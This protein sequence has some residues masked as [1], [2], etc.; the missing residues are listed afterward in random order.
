MSTRGWFGRAIAGVCS[1]LGASAQSPI[2]PLDATLAEFRSDGCSLFPDGR[3]EDPD[4]WCDCY[5]RPDLAYWQDDVPI[6]DHQNIKGHA[7]RAAYLM[8]GV[9]EVAAQTGDERLLT[10]LPKGNWIGG[11]IPYLMT[12]ERGGLT[13]RDQ[14]LVQQL[15]GDEGD[16]GFPRDGEDVGDGRDLGDA[17]AGD[18]P[19]RAD[20]PGADP[21]LDRVD[22]DEQKKAVNSGY[23]PLYRYNPALTAQGKNPLQLDSKA[24]TIDFMEYANN[25]NRY[26]MLKKANPKD[27]DALMKKAAAWTKT[28]FSYYEKL[29]ALNFED[30]CKK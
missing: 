6:Y 14:V 3:P 9:T 15:P 27:A 7:V 24:A 16:A 23:W 18:D 10:Q 26:R 20:G 25:E 4:L 1:W 13:T 30:N 5:L 22:A 19:G 11:T 29:A 28:H 12:D 2:A 17:G 8:S 21:D